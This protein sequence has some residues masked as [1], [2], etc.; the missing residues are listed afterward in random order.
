MTPIFLA[1]FSPLLLRL[2]N[3][4]LAEDGQDLVEYA[5]IIAILSFCAIAS[6]QNV[7]TSISGAF[8]NIASAFN[9]DV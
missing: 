2:K 5:L 7:A 3:K 8:T 9:T 4:F 1:R 6:E